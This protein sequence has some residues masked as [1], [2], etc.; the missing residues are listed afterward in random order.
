[1]INCTQFKLA[2][3]SDSYFDSGRYET[4]PSN[5]NAWS[6]GQFTVVDKDNSLLTGATGANGFDLQ[7]QSG[8][9][10]NLSFVSICLP[11]DES[12][13]IQ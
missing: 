6:I 3:R 9:D 1:V 7:L 5:V 4:H 12:M 2:T 8:I 13:L 10:V 11:C